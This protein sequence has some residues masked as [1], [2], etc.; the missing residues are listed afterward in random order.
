MKYDY[1]FGPKKLTNVIVKKLLL[2]LVQE[3]YI[4]YL[5]IH[6]QNLMCF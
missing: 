6:F 1:V 3:N 4:L 5:Q 2:V